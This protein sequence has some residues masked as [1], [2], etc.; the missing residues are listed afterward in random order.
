MAQKWI[1]KAIFR[2]S[3]ENLRKTI[4]NALEVNL[5]KNLILEEQKSHQK[6]P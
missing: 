1:K 5:D 6:I 3:K 2:G 4:F